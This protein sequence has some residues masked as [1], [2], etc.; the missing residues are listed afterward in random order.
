VLPLVPDEAQREVLAHAGGPLLVL[1]GPGTGKTTTLVEAVA[2]RV[3]AG[4]S[5]D[6]VLVLTFSRKAAQELRERITARLGTTTAG[7]SAWTFHAFCYALVREH[8]SPEVFS[9]PLRLLSGPEQDVALRDLLRGSLDLGRS[10]P[11]VLRAC[12]TTRGLAEEVRALLARA[13]EVGLEPPD[14]A[15][16]AERERREDWAA[17]AGFFGE[18]LDVLDAQ[19]ALDYSE[20]VHRAVLLAERPEVQEQLQSRYKAVFVDEYQD[21]D[22]AQERLLH[23]IAGGGRDLVVVGDP[24][25][26]IYA[27]RGAEVRGILEFPLRFPRA[28]GAPAPVVP[29]RICRRSGPALLEVSRRVAA[30]LP[31]PG[32]PAGRVREHRD[33][34]AGAR[35]AGGL[36][37]AHT[38][39][40]VGAEADAIA[41]L[42]R[43][44]HLERGTPWSRMAVLVRSGARSV[45]LLRRVLTAAGVPL[46]VAGDELP[47]AQEPAVAPLLLALRVADDRAALTVEAARQLLLSPLGGADPGQ[48]RRLGRELRAVD[49][50]ASDDGG[51]RLP[52][53]SAQLLRDAVD[54]PRVLLGLDARVARPAVRLAELLARARAAL[55]EGPEEALWQL[56]AGSPWPQRLEAAS[57]HGGA[58][59]RAAD[60]DLDAVV[61]LFATVARASERRRQ[62]GVRNLVEELEAQQIPG[63]TLA[64]RGVRGDAVRLLTAHRSKGLEWDV[65]VVAGVQEGVWPDLRRRGTLLDAERLTGLDEPELRAPADRAS[66]LIDERRLFYVALTRARRRLVVTAVDSGEQDGERPSRFLAELGVPVTAHT[67]RVA[68]PL[69]LPSLVA[70]LRRESV[71]PRRSPA[72]RR[73][74]AARLARLAAATDDDGAPLTPAAHPRRWWGLALPTDSDRPVQ[75]AGQPVPLSGSSL[76]GLGTCPLRWFLE[77][78]VHAEQATSTAMGFGSVVHA[79]ADEVATGRAPAELDA[80]MARLDT[81][82][83]QLAYDAPWQSAQQHSEAREALRRFLAWHAANRD[84]E[85]VATEVAFSVELEMPGGAVQLRGFM[86][87]VELD[88]DGRVHVIDLKTGKQPFTGKQVESHAQLGTYQLAVRAGALDEQLSERPPVGGAELVMLRIDDGPG[89]KVQQ[90]AS[91]EP[92]PSWVENLLD[93]AVRRI[94][95][96]SFP[97]TPNDRCDRCAFRRCCPAQPDGRQVVE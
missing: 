32:L 14:L 44:E 62:A 87:R 81:V 31:A 79:L 26:S 78:E 60:R 96:E 6:E 20:L 93:T 24:D 80:V 19:G 36:V 25:Q 42:L 8:Q 92:S 40:S 90:Q 1:A 57:L 71:D 67:E 83:N 72:M 35:T 5:P 4:L 89:P 86:D 28:D 22:P 54:D 18:Y 27:F 75:P 51:S 41:D 2:R 97:P 9:E 11:P 68:R 13:R 56:W 30:R 64:E 84:R 58:A 21:T 85:L 73:A 74:A 46:E 88:R 77:H 10:W 17:L 39:P 3:E 59:G 12:L 61:A 38:H 37:E 47:L 55:L 66:L 52:A 34:G 50:R 94:L 33:L 91:L 95:G 45:P 16:L 15:R 65:V 82:W 53:P 23:A 70:A 48:L 43:R 69:S 29:L 7:P 49:R 63:D 76:D